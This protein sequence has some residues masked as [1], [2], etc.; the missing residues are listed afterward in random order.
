[1]NVRTLYQTSK[2]AQVVKEFD[3]YKLDNL[4]VTEARWTEAGKRKLES[5]H[6]MLFS[7]RSDDQH[8]EEV[9]L[10]INNRLEKALTELKPRGPRLLQARFNSR[11]T[12]LTVIVCYALIEDATEKNKD[13]FYGQLQAATEE[14][15]TH[16]MLMIIGDLNARVAEN[17]RDR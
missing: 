12:K 17:N 5:G 4:G 3:N 15:R 1:M 2:L 6:T 16:D 9:A 13:S 10:I 11:Y 7:G 14:V 8:T